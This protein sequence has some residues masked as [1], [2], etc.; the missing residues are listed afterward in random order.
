M[1]LCGRSNI[2]MKYNRLR[3]NTEQILKMLG[4]GI[5]KTRNIPE[6]RYVEIIF[7]IRVI[8]CRSFLFYD[9]VVIV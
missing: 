6:H 9:E 1:S 2:L 5:L 4:G 7:E 3:V 8:L